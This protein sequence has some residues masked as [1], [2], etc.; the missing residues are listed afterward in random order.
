MTCRSSTVTAKCKPDKQLDGCA[1]QA[2][3]CLRGPRKVYLFDISANTTILPQP[4]FKYNG[5]AC[6]E[7]TAGHVVRVPYYLC[8]TTNLTSAHT[9]N[10]VSQVACK[11]D[12]PKC[13]TLSKLQNSLSNCMSKSVAQCPLSTQQSEHTVAVVWKCLNSFSE[14]PQ[15]FCDSLSKSWFQI[16]LGRQ[17]C[18]VFRL[19]S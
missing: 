5:V 4:Q 16:L 7:H 9:L 17:H 10:T 11:I 13:T 8:P 18:Q 15:P 14:T 1:L 2:Q 3:Q 12:Y 6:A 19:K